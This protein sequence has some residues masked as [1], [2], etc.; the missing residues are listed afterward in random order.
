MK[1]KASLFLGILVS[2][3]L[4]TLSGQKSSTE[5]QYTMLG[6][7]SPFMEKMNGK[8]QK[9]VL[10]FYWGVGTGENIKK[11]FPIS[12]RERDSLNWNYDFDATFDMEGDHIITL[13]YLDDNSRPL[14]KYQF[15]KEN[16]KIILA[17]WTMGKDIVGQLNFP[18]GNGYTK[19]IYDKKGQLIR[20]EDYKTDGDVLLYTFPFLNNEAGDPVES[21]ALD[22]NGNLLF[23]WSNSYNEKRQDIGGNWTDKEGNVAGFYK[24]SYNEKG[25][26]AENTMFDKDKNVMDVYKFTYPE[27]DDKGNWLKFII[28][29]KDPS[30]RTVLCERT[31]AYF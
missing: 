5:N 22:N 18:K 3:G 2:I 8:V 19:Y 20:K 21:Q 13:N 27:Y 12:V 28:H 7:P 6:E 1:T 4:T 16:N 25:K 23:K 14:N 11:G 31:I 15:V 10:K 29:R 17:K 30:E 26:I 24:A 9:V